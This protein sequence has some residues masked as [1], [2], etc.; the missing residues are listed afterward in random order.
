MDTLIKRLVARLHLMIA[1]RHFRT[2]PILVFFITS[3]CNSHCRHC[4]NWK[5]LNNKTDLSL[6]RI[7][8][9]TQSMGQVY[10]LLISGGEPYLRKDLPDIVEAFYRNNRLEKI[11]IPTNGL[12]PK[13]IEG[14]TRQ[15]LER[16]PRM[17]VA[18]YLSIDG[19]AP[20][21]D[22]L[23]GV[24]GGFDSVLE[25]YNR[26]SWIKKNTPNL[27][28]YVT[29]TATNENIEDLMDL[30][31]FVRERMPLADGFTFSFIRGSPK[32]QSIHLPS[33]SKLW[34]LNKQVEKAF[35]DRLSWKDHILSYA[36]FSLKM[37]TLKEKRQL[38]PC[39]AGQLVG[40]LYENGDLSNCEMLERITN[41]TDISF[42]QAWN[43]PTMRHQR[44]T[45]IRAGKCHCTHECFLAASLLYNPTG[46]SRAL[47]GAIARR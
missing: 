19:P 14:M 47:L 4:F 20:V 7:L 5:N 34:K 37:K 43:A 22:K 39:V 8:S 41:S 38:I 25:T 23:R 15:I 32:E 1:T 16:C 28:I 44:E 24:P 11:Q 26:L 18:L 35:A 33:E 21:H 12:L 31:H 27:Q 40:V 10:N 17:R 3:R 9:L 45:V 6:D 2:P 29:S 42:E 13:R 36:L 46:L 30:P